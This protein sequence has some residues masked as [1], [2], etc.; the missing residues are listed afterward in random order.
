MTEQE[1]RAKALELAILIQ[2]KESPEIIAQAQR[3]GGLIHRYLG[4][5][6]EIEQ[7]IRQGPQR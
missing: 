2:G 7:Y 6:T 1:I 3:I 5:A 4:L